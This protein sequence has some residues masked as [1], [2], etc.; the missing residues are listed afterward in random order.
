MRVFTM[1]HRCAHVWTK[2]QRVSLQYMQQRKNFFDGVGLTW[3]YVKVQ[4]IR[5]KTTQAFNG[6]QLRPEAHK[7]PL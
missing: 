1:A 4:L 6:F 7:S 2:P 3:E 5:A